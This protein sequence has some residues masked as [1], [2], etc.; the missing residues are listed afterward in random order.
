MSIL[1]IWDE[2][3]QQYVTVPALK[4]P[5]GDKGDTGEQG[6]QGVQGEQGPKGDT[7][8]KG[9]KGDKGD[10]FTYSDFTAQQLADLKGPKGDT[11]DTGAKGD[12]GD[13]GDT[14]EQG[15]QGPKGDDGAAGADGKSAYEYAQDGGYT[16]TEEEFADRMAAEIPE[17]SSSGITVDLT[18][19]GT[20]NT[21]LAT[22][23]FEEIQNGITEGV[24]I[25]VATTNWRLPLVSHD[26]SYLFFS[27]TVYS[28]KCY[29]RT[30]V[31]NS[32]NIV[33]YTEKVLSDE[34]FYVHGIDGSDTPSVDKTFSEIQSAIK[35]NKVVVVVYGVVHCH[36]SEL[37]DDDYVCFHADVGSSC[38]DVIIYNDNSITISE[39]DKSKHLVVNI[40]E[41]SSSI[42]ADKSFTQITN[43]IDGGYKI[44]A[45]F[46][47]TEFPLVYFCESY[48]MFSIA[49]VPEPD[50][51]YAYTVI[52]E[53]T[54][55]VY[56][57]QQN[58]Q[59][60]DVFVYLTEDS[61]ASSGYTANKTFSEIKSLLYNGVMV[62][63]SFEDVLYRIG[64]YNDNSAWFASPYGYLLIQI[65]SDNTVVFDDTVDPTKRI[66]SEAASRGYTGTEDNFYTDLAAL[67]GLDSALAAI[68]GE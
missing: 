29:S 46:G 49:I 8:A 4:G 17:A 18:Y 54:N 16:G 50:Y 60:H 31:M 67:Q 7:G 6:I 23:T 59:P 51:T 1:K 19:D 11:G 55:D 5:K 9:P 56:V 25:E 2:S 13:K 68:L 64:E 10:A 12:K 36:L 43:Y 42:T 38:F 20:N 63:L 14:G 3:Q 32:S 35:A 15:E 57:F 48:C 26:A 22:H 24:D 21:W 40:N 52:I 34:I 41:S 45:R 30:V 27:G 61:N 39:T 66:Y 33:T 28:D 44:Y 65:K 58:V 47:N 53:S 62:Y 37:V